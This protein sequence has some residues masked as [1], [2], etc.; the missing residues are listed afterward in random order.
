MRER[1]VDEAL[2]PVVGTSDTSRMAS[3]EPG[4]PREFIWRG[5]TIEVE[6][7]VRTWRETGKCRHGSQEM[8]VRKHWYEV[9]TTGGAIIKVYFERQPR[10]GEKGSARWWLFSIRE[11]EEG[12]SSK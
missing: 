3:G 7:V 5:K 8:Y 2:T 1:F 4:L 10:R 11:P 6:A 12:P 9:A